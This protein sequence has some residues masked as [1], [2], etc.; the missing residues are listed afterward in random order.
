IGYRG[1]FGGH[2]AIGDLHGEGESTELRGSTSKYSAGAEGQAGGKR[3][4]VCCQSPSERAHAALFE[5][6]L[7][8]GLVLS[9]DRQHSQS[10]CQRRLRR[11]AVVNLGLRT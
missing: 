11:G 2:A 9:R 6:K 5:K 8:V 10:Y 1:G 3:T 4:G 7:R